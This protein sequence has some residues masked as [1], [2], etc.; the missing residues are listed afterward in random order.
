M[1]ILFQLTDL[2]SNPQ[3][4]PN[5][6][7][8]LRVSQGEFIILGKWACGLW[9]VCLLLQQPFPLNRGSDTQP[10]WAWFLTLKTAIRVVVGIDPDGYD[11]YNIGYGISVVTFIWLCTVV[12]T[13]RMWLWSPWKVAKYNR[14][15]EF[16]IGLY[17]NWFRFTSLQD[18]K[19][20][21]NNVPR[22]VSVYSRYVVW[23]LLLFTLPPERIIF[24]SVI[25]CVA[26]KD[27]RTKGV[28]RPESAGGSWV[29]LC[30]CP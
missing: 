11:I 25:V 4:G 24:R 5:T 30:L 18:W 26:Y 2:T 16:F 14:E 7:W 28:C 17:L 8:L 12:A 13:C 20:R 15:A 21:L 19:A 22:M 1:Q 10:L 29:D 23:W 6:F 9:I 3:K 27:Y